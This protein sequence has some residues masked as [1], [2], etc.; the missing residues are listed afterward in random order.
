MTK[1]TQMKYRSY[2]FLIAAISVV[3]ATGGGFRSN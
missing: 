3:A 1:L 2:P